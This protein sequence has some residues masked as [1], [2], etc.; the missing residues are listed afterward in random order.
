MKCIARGNRCGR[1][2]DPVLWPQLQ[3]K[4]ILQEPFVILILIQEQWGFGQGGSFASGT[5]HSPY[6]YNVHTRT[7]SR[8]TRV[9]FSSHPQLW[10]AGLRSLSK[11]ALVLYYS[12]TT[13]PAEK[14]HIAHGCLLLYLKTCGCIS[15]LYLLLY[16]HTLLHIIQYKLFG[17][18]WLRYDTLL[19]YSGECCAGRSWILPRAIWCLFY[20]EPSVRGFLSMFSAQNSSRKALLLYFSLRCNSLFLSKHI[21]STAWLYIISQLINNY[22]L[23]LTHEIC[24]ISCSLFSSGEVRSSKLFWTPLTF[25]AH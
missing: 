2:P 3:R 11:H 9:W 17:L 19:C 13:K 15:S 16:T 25:I 21:I 20:G 4:H 18:C 12:F 6:L 23:L 1:S 5:K 8:K 7:F 14:N 22:Q 10:Q 24:T